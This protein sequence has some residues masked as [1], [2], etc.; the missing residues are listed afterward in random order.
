MNYYQ[1]I[2][3]KVALLLDENSVHNMNEMLM[4]LS[5]DDKLTQEQR[6]E[7]QQRL[8]DAIFVHHNS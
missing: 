6:F 1:E 4:Q 5:H 2:T 3:N 8:R 7:L